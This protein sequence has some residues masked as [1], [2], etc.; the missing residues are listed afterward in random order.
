MVAVVVVVIIFL[1]TSTTTSSTAR[2]TAGARYLLYLAQHDLALE[3]I[4][5][6]FAMLVTDDVG[7]VQ[8]A[9]TAVSMA[10]DQLVLDLVLTSGVRG[11]G[12][13]RCGGCNRGGR[14]RVHDLVIKLSIVQRVRIEA[15]SRG[16]QTQRWIVHLIAEVHIH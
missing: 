16:E 10:R 15:F 9:A 6:R 13:S 4:E 5:L 7:D 8:H 3:L 1:L 14:C 11:R 12:R 2:T